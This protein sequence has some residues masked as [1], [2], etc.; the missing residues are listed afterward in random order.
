MLRYLMIAL[1]LVSACGHPSTS[2]SNSNWI[3][4]STSSECSTLGEGASCIDGACVASTALPACTWAPLS[5]EAG[6]RACSANR[7]LLE[8]ST[9]A[10]AGTICLSDNPTQCPDQPVLGGSLTCHN[11]CD[12]HEYGV[13]CG[14]PPPAIY[15]DPPAG[16]RGVTPVPSGAVFYC[17][18][19]SQ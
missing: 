14:G 1:L 8:C 19:C 13:V 7:A 11:Q 12:P 10:G 15:A 3:K 2:G 17:C 9:E 4:C 18:P 5:A 6:S 16:C